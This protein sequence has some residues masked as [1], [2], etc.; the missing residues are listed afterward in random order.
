MVHYEGTLKE[1][2]NLVERVDGEERKPLEN[3]GD[4]LGLENIGFKWN[5]KGDPACK[6]LAVSLLMDVFH[7]KETVLNRY[8][9]L[10]QNLPSQINGEDAGERPSRRQAEQWGF[11]DKAIA[12]LAGLSSNFREKEALLKGSDKETEQASISLEYDDMEASKIPH[13][14]KGS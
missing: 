3:H 7:D 2:K 1:G 5:R 12:Y 6:T 9:R 11:S 8:E 4:I 10:A 13:E 14:N